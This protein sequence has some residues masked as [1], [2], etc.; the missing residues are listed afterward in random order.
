MKIALAS[1]A[2]ALTAVPAAFAQGDAELSVG[3]SNVDVGPADVGALTGRGSYFFTRNLGVEGEASIGIKDDDVGLGT[4]EL[5][6][7]VGAFG[8]V[9]APVSDKFH[10]F[11]RVGYATSELSVSAPGVG[12]ASGDFDGV[13]YG[14]G[15]KYFATER[16]GFRGDFTKFEGDDSDAD[17]FSVGA[18]VRF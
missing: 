8:V 5:D 4:V 14:V 1:L 13:A 6:H 12:S 16:F 15:A 3:Y 9:R 10:M 11:G 2:I 17:V 7:S 18:V